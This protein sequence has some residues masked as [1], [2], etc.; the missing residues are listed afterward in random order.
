MMH[1]LIK[2]ASIV[3]LACAIALTALSLISAGQSVSALKA[4]FHDLK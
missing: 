1:T 4:S 3:A 2:I